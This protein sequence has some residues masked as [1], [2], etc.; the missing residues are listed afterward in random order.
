MRT[1]VLTP[2]LSVFC[3]LCLLPGLCRAEPPGAEASEPA[4]QRSIDVSV[5][6]DQDRPVSKVALRLHAH[7]T[8]PPRFYSSLEAA[9]GEDG[10]AVLSVDPKATVRLY[11][12]IP[13]EGTRLYAA[14]V[15]GDIQHTPLLR[16]FAIHPGEGEAQV[17]IRL[18]PP[19]AT[20]Q[21]R[22]QG[23]D[24][25]P[26]AGAT[27]RVRTI[28]GVMGTGP[29]AALQALSVRA[30][31]SVSAV[32]DAEGLYSAKVPAGRQH[33]EAV[34][35]PHPS[36]LYFELGGYT[37]GRQTVLSGGHAELNAELKL[38]GGLELKC[39][40]PDGQPVTDLEVRLKQPG[41]H[42]ALPEG[43]RVVAQDRTVSLSGLKPGLCVLDLVPS[44]ES[45]LGTVVG[46]P[47]RIPENALTQLA[48]VLHQGATLRGRVTD[49]DGSPVPGLKLLKVETG[50]NGRYEMLGLPSGPHY[51][52]PGWSLGQEWLW[53]ADPYAR[54]VKGLTHLHDIK[55]ERAP[56]RTFHGKVTDPDGKPVEGAE[57]ILRAFGVGGQKRS[58]THTDATG[59]YRVTPEAHS[60][61]WQIQVLP[62][63]GGG[64]LMPRSQSIRPDAKL[65][66]NVVLQ[67]GVVATL[68]IVDEQGNP[69][70]NVGLR[71]TD[72][73]QGR[74]RHRAGFGNRPVSDENGLLILRLPDRS[75]ERRGEQK[76]ILKLSPGP[77]GTI[78]DQKTIELPFG[79]GTLDLQVTVRKGVAVSGKVVGPEGEPVPGVRLV[80]NTTEEFQ[81]YRA[82]YGLRASTSL[83][84]GTFL[85]E[86]LEPGDHMLGVQRTMGWTVLGGRELVL[87]E[88]VLVKVTPD[89]AQEVVVKM[90]QG[91]SIEG[92][93]LSHDGKKLA[94]G[95]QVKKPDGGWAMAASRQLADPGSNRPYRVAGLKPG[96]YRLK[97]YATVPGW[98]K[99]R[100]R[101]PEVMVTVKAGETVKQDIRLPEMPDAPEAATRTSP[102]SGAATQKLLDA[103]SKVRLQEQELTISLSALKASL[104]GRYVLTAD[105]NVEEALFGFPLYAWQHCRDELRITS[106][107]HPLPL[108]P[109]LDQR[110]YQSADHIRSGLWRRYGLHRPVAEAR[111]IRSTL[112][113]FFN[114]PA[115]AYSWPV[116]GRTVRSYPEVTWQ[117][118]RLS[119][120]AGQPRTVT[121]EATVYPYQLSDT[122]EGPHYA[123]RFPIRLS[124]FWARPPAK[125][126]V[127]IHLDDTVNPED[128]VVLRPE[129]LEREGRAL[130]LTSESLT[131]IRWGPDGEPAGPIEDLY[132]VFA[133]T[134]PKEVRD[135]A[136]WK[137][138][139]VDLE[140][141]VKQFGLKEVQRAAGPTPR[142]V[143]RSPAA[144][145]LELKRKLNGLK[146]L[147]WKKQD[148]IDKSLT[149]YALKT[150]LAI[151][152]S[153][154][155]ELRQFK[156]LLSHDAV[157]V[158]GIAFA[159]REVWLATDK[160][161]ISWHRKN[162]FWT[163]NT[164]SLDTMN[165]PVQ[166]VEIKDGRLIAVF[167]GEGKAARRFEQ[168]LKMGDWREVGE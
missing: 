106:A 70:P 99:V 62:P 77:G 72:T 80:L 136:A 92:W 16:S 154:D 19:N 66:I 148:T 57:V 84:D 147:K 63:S 161:L 151:A 143:V 52:K 167:E 86:G 53:P 9:T 27:V 65:P 131:G 79:P 76:R 61:T 82:T 78:P 12:A 35:A 37:M 101:V 90:E 107:G 127:E 110:K 47:V 30:A 67:K 133:G 46:V 105:T 156:G 91:G 1:N 50:E 129:G 116:G 96:Q 41:V 59:A 88:P 28:R 145:A 117:A 128:L 122:P 55:L 103:W 69:V 32:S 102:T 25:Q 164:P 121:V 144:K 113:V 165:T 8:H 160:G 168:D 166:S 162:E 150:G 81:R 40:G 44:E 109:F 134:L 163:L 33:L 31:E 135:L 49:T 114:Y 23:P 119:L 74:P 126:A 56:L 115:T 60:A 83:A 118:A 34:I 137:D 48:V 159:E 38:G 51:L 54:T 26:V 43:S 157:E 7:D 71:H 73:V 130:K 20:V 29:E 95:V 2:L 68:R 149:W 93:V 14:G 108:V 153:A 138:E 141:Y 24:G 75:K 87:P 123:F 58:T 139:T 125:L 10:K 158:R 22:I 100:N 18:G 39:T 11:S 15:E 3:L 152:D 5:L 146:D 112:N 120:T 111:Y 155:H 17:T 6:D 97:P 94:A 98:H 64:T 85:F 4:P 124:R 42:R 45:S 104:K 140:A 21:G 36:L 89:G 142:T 13:P 132:L